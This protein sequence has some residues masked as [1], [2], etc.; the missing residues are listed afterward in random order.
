MIVVV[1]TKPRRTKRG[2]GCKTKRA[3]TADKEKQ[4]SSPHRRGAEIEKQ[5]VVPDPFP[6]LPHRAKED[7]GG[8]DVA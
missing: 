7:K 4:P 6:T 1:E 8:T 5:E 2:S 3:D